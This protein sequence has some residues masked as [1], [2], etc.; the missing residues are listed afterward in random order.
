MFS[1]WVLFLSTDHPHFWSLT[2]LVL[3]LL[4]FSSQFGFFEGCSPRYSRGVFFFYEPRLLSFLLDS[5]L[6]PCGSLSTS[7]LWSS[8]LFVLTRSCSGSS[9]PP[10]CSRTESTAFW[11]LRRPRGIVLVGPLISV[12]LIIRS[13]RP[14]SRCSTDSVLLFLPYTSAE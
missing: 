14:T 10:S 8:F 4:V 5:P 7:C 3:S 6:S 1:P 11:S 12:L 13:S 2:H 9:T